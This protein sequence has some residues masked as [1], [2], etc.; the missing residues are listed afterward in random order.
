MT[1]KDL[2]HKL[3]EMKS[4][5]EVLIDAAGRGT[6]MI[7]DIESCGRSPVVLITESVYSEG[8]SIHDAE[9]TIQHF[10][11]ERD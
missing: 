3:I 11:D 1:V 4:D 5:A 2:L 7:A 10:T 9:E 6:Y 8:S